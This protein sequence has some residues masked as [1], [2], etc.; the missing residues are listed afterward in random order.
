MYI[1][2]ND[3]YIFIFYLYVFLRFF[4]QFM[5]YKQHK[6]VIN[7]SVWNKSQRDYQV[8]QI[9]LPFILNKINYLQFIRELFLF[10]DLQVL[11]IRSYIL[12][13]IDMIL[14]KSILIIS[15]ILMLIFI[16]FQLTLC[17][18]EANDKYT[19][20]FKQLSE[21][22]FGRTL[23]ETIQIHIASNE[24]ISNLIEM[25]ES[26]ENK[27]I[28]VQEKSDAS[29]QRTKSKCDKD[30]SQL[31]E[32]IDSYILKS[33]QLKSDLELL[34]PQLKV[35]T[36]TVE[37]K[38]KELVEYKNELDK[39][40]IKR[41]QENEQYKQILDDL[42]QALFGVNSVKTE[43]NGFV[44][45]ITKGQQK[46]QSFA[47]I[48]KIM[49]TVRHDI[50]LEG[51]KYLIS[52]ISLLTQQVQDEEIQVQLELS[53]QAIGILKQAEVYIQQERIRE[54]L[55]EQNREQLFQDF[56]KM[57]ENYL[58]S[59][60]QEFVET[61]GLLESISNNFKGNTQDKK[62]IDIRIK[63][64][65]DELQDI[66]NEC[67]VIETEYNTQTAGREDQ[68]NLIEQALILTSTSLGQLKKDLLSN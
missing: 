17:S 51:Y 23:L 40:Q 1:I 53:K 10:L 68:R 5:V 61:S 42:E 43:F 37:R 57:I 26:L 63:Q 67:N 60:N 41:K 31:T 54:D 59:T 24:P 6:Q 45:S 12:S 46:F 16:L 29:F 38:E 19:E 62:E 15:I 8:Q 56:S 44:L 21:T 39:A 3:S 52:I 30:L 20:S 49:K 58:I 9:Y 55:A 14:R 48:R 22:K 4:F 11:Q 33:K 27:I 32:Q 2:S 50:K 18:K 7:D 28:T 35:F 47:E 65:Q 34:N 13:I 36:A 64:K 66:Q 25:F